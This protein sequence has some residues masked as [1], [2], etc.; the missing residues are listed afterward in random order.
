MSTAGE[1]QIKDDMAFLAQDDAKDH[2]K[3]GDDKDGGEESD[4]TT[5]AT[6]PVDAALEVV[7][8]KY[9]FAG[10]SARFMFQFSLASLR[11]ELDRRFKSVLE[12]DSQ[13]FAQNSVSS[14]TPAA[15]NTLMQQFDMDCSPVSKYVL[16]HAYGKCRSKLVKSLR[17]TANS[18][19]NPTLQ[20]WA[21][22][23]EQ[24]LFLF[25]FIRV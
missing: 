11:E 17:A 19:G 4:E 23:L 10:G 8:A 21:F 7:K 1:N 5:D 18:T 3:D 25:G 20:G 24:I 22:E 16:F 15:V 6:M 14:G 9:F 12:S 13:F 2:N